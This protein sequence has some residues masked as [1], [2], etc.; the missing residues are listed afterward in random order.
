MKN[1][2]AVDE[3]GVYVVTV[4]ALY[5]MSA[6]SSGR[7]GWTGGRRTT[8]AAA[9]KPGQLSRGSGTT[10]TVLPGGRVAITDNAE[11]RMHVL[12]YDTATGR[13]SA[14]AGVRRGTRAPP[15]TRWSRSAT[16]W[17]W[18]TTTATPG[19]QSTLLGRATTPGLARV[20]LD[21]DRCRV[22]WTSEEIA[23]TSV[24]KASRANGL[25]YAYTK[26]PTA[27]GVAAWYLT[28][29]DVRTGRTAFS[30]RTG[31]GTLM[32]NHYAAVTLA[33]D[34]SAYIATLAGMV[35]VRDSR[36]RIVRDVRPC[37]RTPQRLFV[38]D[39]PEPQ[40]AARTSS[41]VRP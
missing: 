21:G 29:I 39:Y 4:S 34:G 22:A 2:L 28:A 15:R 14:A 11:P 41:S 40:N 9:Q 1:S 26:R 27:W 3:Q 13:R 7:R 5:K 8:G 31:L 24:A 33:P 35:R 16:A 20:D 32:N 30:V 38:L 37:G 6:D 19:P 25:L 36:N 23:P 12:F 10:P 18:R 17:S